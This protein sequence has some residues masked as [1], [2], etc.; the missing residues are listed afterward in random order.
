[1][2]GLRR[3]EQSE[4]GESADQQS[5]GTTQRRRPGRCKASSA[6]CQWDVGC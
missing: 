4:R 1:L 5:G 3:H 2:G 6:N